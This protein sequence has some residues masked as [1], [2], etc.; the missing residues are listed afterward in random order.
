MLSTKWRRS[1]SMLGWFCEVGGTIWASWMVPV[2][3]EL[4]AVEQHP[5]RRLGGAV[6]HP[7][8][9]RDLDARSGPAPEPSMM[10]SASSQAW[11]SSTARTTME[12]NGLRQVGAE[13]GRRGR[14]ARRRREPVVR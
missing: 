2:V 8:P 11:T 3:V 5:A 4:V 9:R 14:L 1:A 13:A 6:P 7:G 12:R 10:R